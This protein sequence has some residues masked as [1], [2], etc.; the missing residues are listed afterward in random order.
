MPEPTPAPVAAAAS[1]TP[2]P[3]ATSP[4]A[5]GAQPTQPGAG[6][7][8][9]APD[10]GG[11]SAQP[12]EVG[13][14]ISRASQTVAPSYPSAARSARIGGKVTVYLL[15]DEKG[16]VAAVQRTEGPEI[17]RRAA[18]DAARRWRFHPTIIN[19]QPARVT[20]SVAFN[21]AP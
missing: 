9:P 16:Q 17:L 7:V 18:E 11:A 5:S 4:N 1:P 3:A 6:P 12:V 2:T 14:L 10:G 19:G 8:K 13:S 15:L 21:F 20:G